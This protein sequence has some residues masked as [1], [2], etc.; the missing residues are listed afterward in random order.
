[1]AKNEKPYDRAW[2]LTEKALDAYV[3]RDDA[4]GDELIEK[5][6]AVNEKA[7]RDVSEELEQD[8]T[9]QHDLGPSGQKT[10]DNPHKS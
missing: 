5:A 6:K 9:S 10:G 1:M 4:K 3:E 2:T 7:V 8:S